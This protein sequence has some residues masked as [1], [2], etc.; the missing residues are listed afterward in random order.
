MPFDEPGTIYLDPSE[1]GEPMT[2]QI[3]SMDRQRASVHRG[4]SYLEPYESFW[5]DE[6]VTGAHDAGLD[7]LGAAKPLSK[8][9]AAK[10][11]PTAG[12][13]TKTLPSGSK[14]I[15]MK[16]GPAKAGDL[17][18]SARNAVAAGKKAQ[19]SAG[20]LAAHVKKVA[21]K[22]AMGQ[23]AKP[24]K[25]PPTKQALHGDEEV[26]FGASALTSKKTAS[27]KK[28]AHKGLRRKLSHQQVNKIAAD[29]KKKG[30]TSI[31]AGGAL[32]TFH[33]NVM[34]RKTRIAGDEH[35]AEAYENEQAEILHDAVD[36][37]CDEIFGGICGDAIA[38][39]I[40]GDELPPGVSPGYTGPVDPSAGGYETDA[41]FVEPDEE[42]PPNYGAGDPP[43]LDK[44]VLPPGDPDPG[45]EA[46]MAFASDQTMAN[47]VLG[48]IKTPDKFPVPAIRPMPTGAIYYDD[49]HGAIPKDCLCSARY[50][51]D[52]IGVV[53]RDN[54]DIRWK[55]V[56]D[57]EKAKRIV[58]T[59]FF[60]GAFPGI[61]EMM[62]SG[63]GRLDVND[64]GWSNNVNFAQSFGIEVPGGDEAAKAIAAQI[65]SMGTGN[66]WGPIVG[67]SFKSTEWTNMLRL[68]MSTG[69]WFW[70]QGQAPTWAKDAE[71]QKLLKQAQTDWEALRA[72]N[73]DA[74]AQALIDQQAA[75]EEAKANEQ[76]QAR[77]AAEQ[78]AQFEAD[79]A[80]QQ[81]QLELQQQAD[82]QAQTQYQQDSAQAAEEASRQQAELEK[83]LELYERMK[84]LEPPTTPQEEQAS[85]PESRIAPPITPDETEALYSELSQE[86]GVPLDTEGDFEAYEMAET[87]NVDMVGEEE[88]VFYGCEN[89]AK[90]FSGSDRLKARAWAR[91]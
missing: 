23:K 51:K 39:T 36:V 41:D 68:D 59:A 49:S 63:K 18:T 56:S 9:A 21:Q 35:P 78:Q 89:Q 46:S 16:V 14:A 55:K 91:R 33:K 28:P 22:R 42:G 3:P 40:Y 50:A 8:S 38:D 31:K 44:I 45:R 61:S 25:L 53:K 83:E 24:V 52:G 84:A 30:G 17:R 26:V 57:A 81:Q 86:A 54:W 15:V 43:T 76:E 70:F 90:A 62:L 64:D 74:Y 77:L 11:K 71:R 6:V 88:E 60:W 75:E 85:V 34:S 19:F 20:K 80:Y 82:A 27:T 12:F 1:Y 7:V 29:I 67:R 32:A 69:K 65:L 79:Q 72:A 13:T 5:G 4:A 66:N 73:A 47:G 37:Q 48:S 87:S 2:E 58:L 10:P